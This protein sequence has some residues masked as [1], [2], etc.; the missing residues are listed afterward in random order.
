VF[1][2]GYGNGDPTQLRNP[3]YATRL[4]NGNTIFVDTGNHRVMEVTPNHRNPWIYGDNKRE[5]CYFPNSAQRLPN[6]N[7]LIADTGN[8]RVIEVNKDGK[9]VWQLTD[10]DQPTFAERL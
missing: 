6:G 5:T 4:P 2:W 1:K 8:N 9:I 10:L 3:K 7:T